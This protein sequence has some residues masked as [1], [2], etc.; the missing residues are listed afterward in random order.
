[1]QQQNRESIQ[2]IEFIVDA[3]ITRINGNEPVSAGEWLDAAMK[4]NVLMGNLDDALVEAEMAVNQLFA[5][6]IAGDMSV[7]KAKVLRDASVEYKNFIELRAAKERINGMIMLAKKRVGLQT[8]D[9]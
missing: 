6:Y 8:F 2:S 3:L 4:V 5:S 9:Y 1:M 7:A